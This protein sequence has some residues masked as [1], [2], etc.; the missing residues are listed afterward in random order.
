MINVCSSYVSF[1]Q[2]A[3]LHPIWKGIL[4]SFKKKT[5]VGLTWYQIKSRALFDNYFSPMQCS[6]QNKKTFNALICSK[7][8][9]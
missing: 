1:N 5:C 4:F 2:N 7:M 6:G 3:L 8:F 9:F